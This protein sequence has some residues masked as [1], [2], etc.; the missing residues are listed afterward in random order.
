MQGNR[1]WSLPVIQLVIFEKNNNKKNQQKKKMS[2][3]G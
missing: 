2:F 3:N 1:K